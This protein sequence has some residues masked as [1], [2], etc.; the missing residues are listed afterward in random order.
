MGCVKTRGERQPEKVYTP[1]EMQRYEAP[2]PNHETI[3]YWKHNMKR[4][5]LGADKSSNSNESRRRSS[6]LSAEL[7][8]DGYG[9]T[10]PISEKSTLEIAELKAERRAE[11]ERRCMELNPPLTKDMLA[12]M[13]SYRTTIQD[14]RPL[15]DLGWENLKQ[16]LLAERFDSEIQSNNMSEFSRPKISQYNSIERHASTSDD[17]HHDNQ[18]SVI[19][20]TANTTTNDALSIPGWDNKSAEGNNPSALSEILSKGGYSPETNETLVGFQNQGTPYDTNIAKRLRRSRNYQ[21]WSVTHNLDAENRGDDHLSE[22]PI[23]NRI[24]TQAFDHGDLD[25]CGSI[26]R[27]LQEILPK[28]TEKTTLGHELAVELNKDLT[29]GHQERVHTDIHQLSNHIEPIEMIEQSG[30][31]PDMNPNLVESQQEG[32]E[33]AISG[34]ENETHDQ[35]SN[36]K[37]ELKFLKKIGSGHLSNFKFAISP[38]DQS[39]SRNQSKDFNLGSCS[40]KSLHAGATET[41]ADAPEVP[42]KGREIDPDIAIN[43]HENKNDNEM[44]GKAIALSD[45]RLGND[46]E[47]IIVEGQVIDILYRHGEGWLVARDLKTQESGLVLERNICVLDR[48][49]QGIGSQDI[50]EKLKESAIDLGNSLFEKSRWFDQMMG[51]ELEDAIIALGNAVQSKLLGQGW[52]RKTLEMHKE[53]HMEAFRNL[54]AHNQ[55]RQ[56]LGSSN[57]A[58][59]LSTRDGTNA[60]FVPRLPL[61]EV[62]IPDDQS[63]NSFEFSATESVVSV[64]DSI[65]SAISLASGSSMSSLSV[66]Q[67]A[68]DRLVR[69]LL[70]DMVIKQLCEDALWEIM[71][72]RGRF[73]RNLGRLLKA[74]AVELRKEAQTR[75]ERQAA[76]LVR[77]R[78]RNSA[79]I[80]CSTLRTEK[81]QK[82][83]NT[84]VNDAILSIIGAE[85]KERDLD[86]DDDS[87]SASE[88]SEDTPNDFQHLENFVRD[89]RA[90]ESFRE[91]LRV[92]IHSQKIQSL[93]RQNSSSVKKNILTT[94]LRETYEDA[95]KE[96]VMLSGG[97]EEPTETLIEL[98]KVSQPPPSMTFEILRRVY[99]PISQ[100]LALLANSITIWKRPPVADGKKRIEWRCVSF[101]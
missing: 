42:F 99:H 92:F 29:L 65:F 21:E 59:S 66:S 14:I 100:K 70:D 26:P 37:D 22:G 72:S 15:T 71:M 96:V 76:H 81:A 60:G 10:N 84:G 17:R 35:F 90:F 97:A 20:S 16:N 5:T 89:S 75:E 94:A 27:E 46:N 43:V 52:P 25:G 30:T 28:G 73:E 45:F 44:H 68:T 24:P 19:G 12:S 6:Q 88:S 47:V 38:A 3:S 86:M 91:K 83:A 98:T 32:P 67:T 4:E 8:H 7:G 41:W 77:F 64:A 80:I 69:L 78:A 23:H 36:M 87:D 95:Y 101:G 79:H 57:S 2:I 18:Y 50:E 56:S 85:E 49:V 58:P 74:F 63:H 34:E 11:I 61:D 13:P 93:S 62:D 54:L 55:Q 48:L 39:S 1:F 9:Y 51:N 53:D 82:S 31:I 33:F 40:T